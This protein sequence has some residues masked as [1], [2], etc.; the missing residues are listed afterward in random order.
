MLLGWEG[1]CR[2]QGEGGSRLTRLYAS[3]PLN[4]RPRPNWIITTTSWM[5]MAGGAGVPDGGI[6]AGSG[7]AGYRPGLEG[8]TGVCTLTVVTNGIML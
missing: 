8:D 2:Q 1:Y 6:K 5:F 7:R 3:F 4:D